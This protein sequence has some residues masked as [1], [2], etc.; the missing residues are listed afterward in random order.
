MADSVVEKLNKEIERLKGNLAD[1]SQANITFQR[2][3]D[4]LVAAGILD[5]GKFEQAK[6]LVTGL[7]W[8]EE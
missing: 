7:R 8:R 3:F 6:E 5:Q 4:V 2:T 1:A